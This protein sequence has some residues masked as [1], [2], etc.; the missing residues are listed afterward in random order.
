MVSSTLSNYKMDLP[1]SASIDLQVLMG[2]ILSVCF[3]EYCLQNREL[4]DTIFLKE[5][6][7]IL[8]LRPSKE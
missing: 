2:H 1:F 4:G 3:T 5:L 7:C 8:N 6:D